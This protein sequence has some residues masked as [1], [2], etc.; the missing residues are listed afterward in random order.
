MGAHLSDQTLALNVGTFFVRRVSTSYQIFKGEWK[1]VMGGKGSEGSF[2]YGKKRKRQRFQVL[3]FGTVRGLYKHVA[4][5][6][7]LSYP[8]LLSQGL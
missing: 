6:A 4:N 3:P 5:I 2:S 7:S 1:I 8:L